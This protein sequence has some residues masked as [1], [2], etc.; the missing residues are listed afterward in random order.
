M[1]KKLKLSPW[2]DGSVNPVR[3][4][5]YKV[6]GDVYPEY[7][8]SY[9]DGKRFNGRWESIETAYEERYYGIGLTTLKWSGVL[10]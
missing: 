6:K 3:K 9:F 7:C 5:V 8:W 10:K 4:G 2:H 1:N